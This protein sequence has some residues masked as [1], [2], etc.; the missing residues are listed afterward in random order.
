MSEGVKFTVELTHGDGFGVEDR[1]VDGLK[2]NTSW[3]ACA[4]Q[5][6]EGI[7]QNLL[8]MRWRSES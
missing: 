2:R 5:S 6:R 8:E 4:L 7:S 3:G 1:C